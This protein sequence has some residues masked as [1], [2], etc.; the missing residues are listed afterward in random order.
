MSQRKSDR[1][2]LLQRLIESKRE[3]RQRLTRRIQRAIDADTKATG[4]DA[5]IVVRYRLLR[6]LE[7]AWDREMS[8]LRE[9]VDA[10]PRI[11]AESYRQLAAEYLDEAIAHG[12]GLKYKTL[13]AQVKYI[14]FRTEIWAGEATRR[15]ERLVLDSIASGRVRWDTPLDRELCYGAAFDERVIEI[16]LAVEMMDL[17]TPGKI[18][19]AGAALNHP[20]LRPLLAAAE[21]RITHLTQSGTQEFAGFDANRISY[22]FGDL[23]STDYRDGV[24]DRIVCISTLERW[25]MLAWTTLV[26]GDPRSVIP[27]PPSSPSGS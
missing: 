23:R 20:F 7:A 22:V 12:T 13:A 2:T 16:P 9:I 8:G 4:T 27:R 1:V 5:T 24:F 18:L 10:Y 21:A 11:F 6:E 15:R 17:A 26:M 3:Q 14:P 25:S 19:D